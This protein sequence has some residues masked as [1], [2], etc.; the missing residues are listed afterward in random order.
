M[1]KQYK[2]IEVC[3]SCRSPKIQTKMWVEVN[4]G[5]VI[6]MVSDGEYEDNWCPNCETNCDIDTKKIKI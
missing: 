2:T 3:K 6:S 5:N 4:T 1:T